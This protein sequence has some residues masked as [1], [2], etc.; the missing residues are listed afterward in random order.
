[1]YM[2]F[3][4][5]VFSVSSDVFPQQIEGVKMII[6]K[7][8]SSFFK[9][10]LPSILTYIVCVMQMLECL[11]MCFL[12]GQSH[13]AS[14]CCQSFVLQI[15]RGASAVG[16]LQQRQGQE[17]VVT[18]KTCHCCFIMNVL[19]SYKQ[20][21]WPFS[22]SHFRML[23]HWSVKWTP[24]VVWT[25]TLC[26]TSPSVY[27]P[28]RC[29][30]WRPDTR[31]SSFSHFFYKSQLLYPMCCKHLTETPG[32]VLDSAVP[33][34][35]VAVWDGVQGQWLH[36]CRHSSQPR[37]PQRV[38]WWTTR[39][40]LEHQMKCYDVLLCYLYKDINLCISVTGK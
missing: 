1:M 33:V 4:M 29:S 14:Q 11:F 37:R 35:Y 40:S 9:V 15:P 10:T 16:R 7:T 8:L 24:P 22:S 27:E 19:S 12:P 26:C 6:N 20:S 13:S 18:L 23:L 2:L 36:R 34:C 32:C 38:R 3:D 21:C 39:A 31:L 30:R 28:G 5:T 25:L 17:R